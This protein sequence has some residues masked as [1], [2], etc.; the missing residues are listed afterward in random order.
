MNAGP[1]RD[2]AAQRPEGG[3]HQRRY[4]GL[5]TDIGSLEPGKLADVIVIDGNPLADIRVT[6]KVTHTMINGRLY[7]A[8][9]MDELLPTPRK[10]GKFFWEK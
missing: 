10:R 5:D 9:T 7:D 4:L 6:E 8:S 2:D 1:G 3:H